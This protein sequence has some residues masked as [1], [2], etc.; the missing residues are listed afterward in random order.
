MVEG[1]GRR[2]A[3]SLGS[4]LYSSKHSLSLSLSLTERGGEV[5]RVEWA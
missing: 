3:R 5:E 2:R 4:P 1:G